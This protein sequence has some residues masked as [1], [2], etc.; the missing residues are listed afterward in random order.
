MKGPLPDLDSCWC[1]ASKRV[2]KPVVEGHC[3]QDIRPARRRLKLRAMG[4]RFRPQ[5]CHVR[6]D[7]SR[8]YKLLSCG[9][10][11][12]LPQTSVDA[13]IGTSESGC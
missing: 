1:P 7:T 6:R 4:C 2:P 12:H 3:G 10:M 9:E 5:V 8:E 11:A 13:V